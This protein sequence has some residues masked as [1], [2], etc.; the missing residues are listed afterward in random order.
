M[1]II[2][3]FGIDLSKSLGVKIEFDVFSGFG[4]LLFKSIEI[5]LLS[6]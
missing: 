1:L 6:K 2:A 3:L 5:T 4:F